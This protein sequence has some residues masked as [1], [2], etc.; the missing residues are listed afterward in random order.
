MLSENDKKV[1]QVVLVVGVVAFIGLFYYSWAVVKGRMKNL[2]KTIKTAEETV[3]QKQQ[4]LSD[5]KKWQKRS[6]E[7]E[8]LITELQKK[9]SRLPSTVEA[10]E[11]FSILRECVRMTNLT[12]IKI[13]RVKSVS[14]GMYEEIPYAITCRAR[15]H[16]LGQFLA[17]V[18]Q[19][20]K[21]IMRIKT[22]DISNDPKRPSRH[23]VTMKIATFVFTKPLPKTK[24]VA[25]K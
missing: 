2:D 19:H 4:E 14:M 12:N 11:F 25:S 16:D 17:L 3:R 5:M 10:R 22:L 8:G 1:L 23:P 18:E 13:A 15:Y 6:A 21:Q 7:I 9:V 24:E 20:R